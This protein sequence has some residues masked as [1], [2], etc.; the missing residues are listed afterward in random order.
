MRI[1]V[2]LYFIAHIVTNYCFLMVNDK[3]I[4]LKGNNKNLR[5]V[6]FALSLFVSSAAADETKPKTSPLYFKR[7]R[8]NPHETIHDPILL[9]RV[10]AYREVKVIPTVLD[11]LI[12]F[13]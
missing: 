10:A 12:W 2:F 8:L 3:E 11:T 4:A 1:A 6:N 5:N 13:L 9:L 7:P